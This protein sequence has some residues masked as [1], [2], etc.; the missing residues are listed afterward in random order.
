VVLHSFTP[1]LGLVSPARPLP[2]D[3]FPYQVNRVPSDP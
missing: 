1:F 2:I 3:C